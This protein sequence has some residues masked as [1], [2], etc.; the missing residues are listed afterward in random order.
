MSTHLQKQ[1]DRQETIECLTCN[2]RFFWH[3]HRETEVIPQSLV[4]MGKSVRLEQTDR[5]FWF[6]CVR[7]MEIQSSGTDWWQLKCGRRVCMIACLI[8]EE[9]QHTHTHTLTHTAMSAAFLLYI[10]PRHILGYASLSGL[11]FL[12]EQNQTNTCIPSTS[13]YPLWYIQTNVKC[14][15]VRKERKNKN[16]T[17]GDPPP[18]M[19]TNK[20]YFEQ[21]RDNA[22]SQKRSTGNKS[23]KENVLKMSYF[24]QRGHEDNILFHIF[25]REAM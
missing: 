18:W 13:T 1:K 11:L 7:N 24:Y 9:E 14:Q 23:E 25:A 22:S 3:T 8:W 16:S 15:N 19:R 4:K 2:D 17:S 6:F 20:Q 10:S 21:I 5:F 12:Q